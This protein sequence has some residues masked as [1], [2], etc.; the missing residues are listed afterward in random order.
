MGPIVLLA[1]VLLLLY[2]VAV[3]FAGPAA[4]ATRGARHSRQYAVVVTVLGAAVVV[5]GAVMILA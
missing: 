1:G 2:G 3:M 4:S 5:T